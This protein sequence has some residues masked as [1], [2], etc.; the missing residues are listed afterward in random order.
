[1]WGR[2]SC[3]RVYVYIWGRGPRISNFHYLF[4]VDSLL[5]MFL[6]ISVCNTRWLFCYP[7][8]KDFSLSLFIPVAVFWFFIVGVALMLK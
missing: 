4:I 1:V 6:V 3:V 8:M 2:G 7:I 5:N